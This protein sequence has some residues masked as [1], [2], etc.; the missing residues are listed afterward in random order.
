MIDKNITSYDCVSFG[1]EEYLP[2]DDEL[3]NNLETFLEQGD[4]DVVKI[5]EI[6][7][8]DIPMTRI[9]STLEH[10]SRE[11]ACM[12]SVC[13]YGPYL[14]SLR[15]HLG[16][17][18]SIVLNRSMEIG[19]PS[20]IYID[21]RFDNTSELDIHK[22]DLT[23]EWYPIEDFVQKRLRTLGNEVSVLE[24]ENLERFATAYFNR[25]DDD[26]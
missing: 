11:V 26:E 7:E 16:A 15:G 12:E 19:E 20:L 14:L 17:S 8:S 4:A 25:G 2:S 6:S 21:K 13:P 22:C 5:E 9:I 18:A 24:I 3:T 23:A 1:G 10:G